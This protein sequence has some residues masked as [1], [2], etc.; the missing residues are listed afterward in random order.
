MGMLTTTNLDPC[1]LNKRI[2]KQARRAKVESLTL[3][4]QMQKVPFQVGK[5]AVLTK[6]FSGVSS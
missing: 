4:L 2:Q 6:I 1:F 3:L 5:A